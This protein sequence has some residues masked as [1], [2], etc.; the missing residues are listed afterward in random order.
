MR[1]PVIAGNWKMNKTVQESRSLVFDISK[2]I[3]EF[4]NVTKILFPPFMSLLPAA[5][6][7]TGTEIAL[8]AQ[9]MHWEDKGAFT[10]ETSP[11][12]VAEFCKYVLVGHSERRT[13]FDE[14]DEIVNKKLRSALDHELIPILCIGESLTEKDSELTSSVL[15]RQILNGYKNVNASEVIKTIIAYE[16]I[17]AIGTGKASS[18]ENANVTIQDIIRPALLDLYGD[19]I[20]NSVCV[21]YGGSVTSENAAE[22]FDHDDIDGALVGGASLQVDQFVEIVRICSRK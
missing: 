15:K 13:Y 5:S 20:A 3:R 7:L 2:G 11:L 19:N 16:P 17:W 12:M 6:L 18:G 8:G 10:G 9:N 21:L 22:F 14:T 4:N 1:V